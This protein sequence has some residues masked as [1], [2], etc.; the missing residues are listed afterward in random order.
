MRWPFRHAAARA[1]PASPITL[2]RDWAALA[3]MRVAGE[4]PIRLTSSHQR[5]IDAL[6]TERVLVQLPRLEQVRRVDSPSG[7]LRAVTAVD[8]DDTERAFDGRQPLREPDAA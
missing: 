6:A 8:L 2:R 7:T 4:R 3:P 1:A 5:F